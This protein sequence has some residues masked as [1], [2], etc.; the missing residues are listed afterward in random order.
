M[1]TFDEMLGLFSALGLSEEQA[2]VAAIG[3]YRSEAEARAV[4]EADADEDD[5]RSPD[6]DLTP[7]VEAVVP[8]VRQALGMTHPEAREYLQRLHVR[9]TAKVGPAGADQF[10]R[11]LADGLR[12]SIEVRE[13]VAR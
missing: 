11:S 5:D 4:D 1:G 10:V 2:R 13:R 6:V 7:A 8:T 9:E 3:R 12:R